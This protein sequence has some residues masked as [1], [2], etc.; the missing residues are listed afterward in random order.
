MRRE[1][2]H[3]HSMSEGWRCYHDDV[4]PG[5]TFLNLDRNLDGED[6]TQITLACNETAR[7]KLINFVRE[8]RPDTGSV[9]V[10]CHKCSAC[11]CHRPSTDNRYLHSRVSFI[12]LCLLE[13]MGHDKKLAAI[14]SI[15][16][17]CWVD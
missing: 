13:L 9:T 3:E 5:N 10:L 15:Q 16:N 1:G 6:T 12:Q 14:G 17:R 2:G 4:C 11:Q 8:S 7:S